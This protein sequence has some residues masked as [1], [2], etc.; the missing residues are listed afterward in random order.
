MGNKLSINIHN[1]NNFLFK[2]ACKHGDLETIKHLVQ[3]CEKDKLASMIH[4]S[5]DIGFYLACQ[6]GHL[7]I[8]KY[9]IHLCKERNLGDIN[10]DE[11]EIY[12]IVYAEGNDD[13]LYW[14]KK[15]GYIKN[16]YKM[17]CVTFGILCKNGYKTRIE[18]IFSNMNEK[19]IKNFLIC[20]NGR[21]F[22]MACMNNQLE[23]VEYLYSLYR[24]YDLLKK[25]EF[26]CGSNEE[27][28]KDCNTFVEICKEGYIDIVKFLLEKK[29]GIEN[30]EEA[31]ISACYYGHFNIAF[32]LVEMS[33]K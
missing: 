17:N 18:Y 31:Y 9:L 21:A 25:I 10:I 11:K 29:I 30:I 23:I 33:E 2:S 24:K 12:Q 28:K 6:K 22:D 16:K 8:I 5:N 32:L 19:E 20:D 3:I 14:L 15:K 4:N 1:N 7:I 26:N 13:I 27:Y